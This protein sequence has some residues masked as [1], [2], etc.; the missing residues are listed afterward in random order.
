MKKILLILLIIFISCTVPKKCCSQEIKKIF[1]F[2][3]FYAAAS[4]GTSISDV[5]VFSVTNG[6]ETSI[7]QT[8]FDYNLAFGIR[9][10]ARFGYENRAN[11][12]YDG[13]ETSWSDAANIGK[14]SGL[15]FLFEADIKRQ[16][17]VDYLDQHHF[18][19]YVADSWILKGEYLQDGFADI[20]YFET[21]Q[22]YRYNIG[23]LSFNIGAAQRLSEP[24]GYDPLEEWLLDNGGIHY[25][26]LAIQE[27]YNIDVYNS[28]YTDPDGKV[29][30]TN[31]EVWEEVV[32]P[33]M[34]SDYT[35]KKRNELERKMQQSLVIG[36]DY[37]YYK[38]DFWLHSWGNIMPWHYDDGGTF[39]YHNYNDGNQWYDYSGGLIFG[40]KLSKSL[41]TF[42]EGKY[43]K[44]WNR[45]WY[46]FKFGVNYIIF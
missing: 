7:V 10:I 33:Q 43:N 37:Y 35:E 2:S 16:E 27:G 18:I 30:A 31:P 8:P 41:G 34:L 3:T 40:Y 12:F 23:K 36:F 1:K 14:K 20:K 38:K 4:G 39:S 9:K 32:I 21:S 46:D 25:T 5:D 24:Y 42:I 45:E 28:I 13:T 6:L 11:T 17:G 22:R 44:Y 29:V 15:E 19:R 26:Y